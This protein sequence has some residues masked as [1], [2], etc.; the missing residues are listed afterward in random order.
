MLVRDFHR[1]DHEA[2]TGFLM[3]GFT[4]DLHLCTDGIADKNGADETQP[5]IAISHSDLVDPIGRQS[6]GDAENECSM[7]NAPAKRLGLA[8]FFVYMMGKKITRLA[9]VE[10]DV[11]L[12]DRA[13]PGLAGMPGLELFVKFLHVQQSWE[14]MIEK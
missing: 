7:G 2:K 10:D 9:G 4:L 5:V 8:P 1:F 3:I 11:R 13:P 6:D 12:R 14:G